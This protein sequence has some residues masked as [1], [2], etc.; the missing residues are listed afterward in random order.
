MVAAKAAKDA[1]EK[2]AILEQPKEEDTVSQKGGNKS[3]KGGSK[4]EE[5]PQ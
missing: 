3:Q 1:K 5:K 2:E 4:K